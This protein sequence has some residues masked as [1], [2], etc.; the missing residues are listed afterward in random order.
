MKKVSTFFL[1][2]ELSL[3]K[4]YEWIKH[5]SGEFVP[6]F[7][8][9]NESNRHFKISTFWCQEKV[10][11]GSNSGTFFPYILIILDGKIV[12]KIVLNSANSANSANLVNSV[13]SANSSDNKKI[14]ILRVPLY[15]IERDYLVFRTS[16]L[17]GKEI[18][19]S[20]MFLL[21]KRCG[22]V[23]LNPGPFNPQWEN[24]P[25][26]SLSSVSSSSSTTPSS[27][28][29]SATLSTS[30]ST[31]QESEK[32]KKAALQVT[33]LNVRGLGDPKKVRHL[34]NSC[35]KKCATAIENI[36]MFQETYVSSL[37]LLDYI[38]RGDYHLTPGSGS[39]LGCI[40]LLSPSFKVIQA[41]NIGDRGHILAISRENVNKVD[42]IIANIYAPNGL[43][44]NKTNYIDEAIEKIGET[45]TLYNCPTV[46]LAGDLNIVFDDNEVKNRAFTA[47][48]KRV[49][50]CVKESLD[51]LNLIDGWDLV[52]KCFTWSANRNGKHIFSILDRILFTNGRL[53]LLGKT[54]DWSLSISDH[55]AVTA[56]F[57]KPNN[58]SNQPSFIPRIDPCILEDPECV[59]VMNETYEAM[60]NDLINSWDP[61][62][63]L[64]YCKLCIRTAANTATG[65]MKAKYRD[66]EAVLNNDINNVVNLLSDTNE[67]ALDY[68][69]LVNKLED[70]R[71][72]KRQLVQKIGTKLER[73]TANKWYNEGELS[74][75]YFFNLLNRRSNDEISSLFI[76]NKVCNDRKKINETVSSFYKSLYENIP[77]DLSDNEDFFRHID[78]VDPQCAA[79][80]VSDIT[81]EELAVTLKTCTDSAPGPDGIPYSL[82]RHYWSTFGPLLLS[83]WQYSLATESLPPS[84]KVSYLRLIPKAGKDSR[85][86]GNLRPITLSN[87]DHKLITKTYSRKLTSM[88]ANCIGHEQTAYIPGRLINDNIRA[89]LTTMD[90]A[91]VDPTVEGCIVSLDARKAFDSVDHRYIIRCLNAFGLNSF[92]PIFKI[93]YKDLTSDIILNGNVIT[94]YRILRGVKQGDALS[95]IL[96][97]MC[98][99]PLIRNIKNNNQIEPI[100]SEKLNINIPN[101]YGFADDINAVTKA[102]DNG[103]QEIFNEYQLFTLESGLQ[104]NA[105]KTEI[106]MF[107]ARRNADKT[108]SVKYLGSEYDVSAKTSIKIN[109]IIFQQDPLR[110][111]EANVQKVIG[112]MTTHLR[113]W[114]RR[115]L[116]LL[117]KILILKTFAISQVIFTMQSIT[118]SDNSLKKINALIYKYLWNKNFNASKAPDRIKRSIVTT[119]VSRGGLGMIDLVEVGKSLDLRAYGRLLVSE[120]PFFLQISTS[121]KSKGFFNVNLS[122]LAVDAKFKK[123]IALLNAQRGKC[124]LWPAGTIESNVNLR[125]AIVNT[126]LTQVLTNA[127]RNSLAAF[128]VR[129]RDRKIKLGQLTL[130]EINDLS[131]HFTLQGLGAT[132][133]SLITNPMNNIATMP[134]HD[135]FPISPGKVV[136]MSQTTS[137]AF[138]TSA[139]DL[140]SQIICL[141]KSGLTLLPGEVLNWTKKIKKLTSSR[142]KNSVLRI[143]HGDVYTNDRL[144]RFG[145]TDSPRCLHCDH[146]N[147]NL[148]HRL[149]ECP[150]AANAW[151]QLNIKLT[152]LNMN[153]INEVTL[154]TIIGAGELQSKI[155]L[156]LVSELALRLATG[157]PN[158]VTSAVMVNNCLRFVAIGEKLSTEERR[159]MLNLARVG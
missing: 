71:T 52:D 132:L 105:D 140:E 7:E 127:G 142:H 6:N 89:M 156:T 77:T 129:R 97:I 74:N 95:C 20:W 1:G 139:I 152:E 100:T 72:L 47:S 112:A 56:R 147:E 149:I 82:I 63:K 109:G 33:T 2:V 121:V 126:E 108:F 137:K 53:T 125:A 135:L 44:R 155:E 51:S 14:V 118:L 46:I 136:Q 61:H 55:A 12:S 90:L 88:V 19:A 115:H 27:T 150:V 144:F 106:L 111:E 17:N 39:S 92:V 145:L 59:Q 96:F 32:S 80:L 3:V 18:K 34:V 81:L 114:S 9:K 151:Q 94:G 67:S 21:L 48:E 66:E 131:R 16:N 85:H 133:R 70:L 130:N 78:S 60:M 62:M 86:I 49:A 35:Y 40:T 143:A 101:V 24:P 113:Q 29:T 13:N 102:T 99:E 120:H 123:G 76:D 38:W 148:M 26:A 141:Y 5:L 117:G 93:L 57:D 69:V 23:E 31:R 75:K 10:N 37:K 84:H 36:F 87:T 119:P 134:A 30:R 73:R 91:D 153:P 83:A 50:R 8:V 15:D 128:S 4:V 28:S 104:L 116:T 159:T 158:K 110:R 98:M 124:L 122:H 54:A 64:E 11:N 157:N 138:R 146:L 22:D 42:Y 79:A 154:E 45:Q 65:K 103:V 43:D 25:S 68:P 107:N 41:I 58:S